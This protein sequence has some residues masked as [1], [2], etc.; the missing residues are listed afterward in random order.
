MRNPFAPLL[1]LA[2]PLMIGA[3]KPDPATYY[4]LTAADG[5]VIGTVRQSI[6]VTAAGRVRTADQLLVVESAGEV[7]RMSDHVVTREDKAGQLLS[8]SKESRT[9]PSITRLEMVI[10]NGRAEFVRS[11]RMDQHKVS[12]ALP[13][14]VRFDSGTGLLAG[15]DRKATPRL[16]FDNLNLESMAIEHVVIASA[17]AA[18]NDQLSAFRTRYEDGE[19]RGIAMLTIDRRGQIGAVTQPMFGSTTTLAP[20]DRATALKPHSPFKMLDTSMVKAK[21]RIPPG[22][23]SGHIRYRFGFRNGLSFPLP[24]TSE[25][26]MAIDGDTS[27][28]DICTTCGTGLPTDRAYLDNALKP[29]VWLQSD[30]PRLKAIVAPVATMRVSDTRKMEILLKR[31]RPY[32]GAV[33][34]AGHFSALETLQRRKSDCTEAA[35]LLAALGRSA[36]IPT[37][38]ADGLVYSRSYYHKVSNA[39][40]PHSWTLAFVDGQWRSFDLALGDFDASHIA[41]TIGDGDARSIQAANQLAGLLEWQDVAEIRARPKS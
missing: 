41:L 8:V 18:S 32:L 28:V 34:F 10:A 21:F 17:P 7:T 15:W 19:F 24:Q 37:K 29:T 16:E 27:V 39:F 6:V 5:S 35:V 26:R 31:A 9:G 30:H 1:I 13:A 36:G 2:A 14:G 12:V 33:S 11:T 4:L 23:L 25:Q 22:A 3:T 38:V 20:T 40:M